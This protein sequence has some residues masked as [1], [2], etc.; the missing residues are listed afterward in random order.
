M[1]LIY[2]LGI[3]SLILKYVALLMLIPCFCALALKEYTACVP[4]VI[5]SVFTFFVSFL[6]NGKKTNEDEINNINKTEAFSVLL[7]TWGGICILGTIP[8]LYFGLNFTDSLFESVSGITA[9]GASVLK[10]YANYPK[11]MFFWRAFSQWIGGMGVIVLFTAI[12][13][14]IVSSGKQIFSVELTGS[15]ENKLT[16]R[17]KHTAIA[18]WSIYFA[19]TIIEIFLLICMKMPIFDA[20]C[21]S[22]SCISSGGFVPSSNILIEYGQLKYIW[23]IAIFMFFAG[24]NFALQYK[25]FVKRDFKTLLKN[26]EFKIYCSVILFFTI[27]ISGSLILHNTNN[28]IDTVRNSLFS[29]LSIITTSG[30]VSTDYSEWNLRAKLFLFLLMFSGA[31]VGSTTGGVKILRLIF[32]FKYMK[33]QISKI[34]HPNGVYPIKINKVIVNE[35]NVKKVIS[36]VF[37]YYVFFVITAIA[38]IYTE[39]DIV[40]GTTVAISTLGNIGIGFGN[41]IGPMGHFGD[42]QLS[43]KIISI[44]NML[45]GRLELIPFLA[46]LHTD[47][48]A[49]KKV[50]AF[51]SSLK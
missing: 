2:V 31:C 44:F 25:V 18:L 29:V 46:L 23:T 9:T 22:L 49:L 37:F 19:L 7:L 48:W 27:I 50:T 20:I 42:L 5:T 24:T 47:F 21:I 3:V 28:I 6:L 51:K 11:T 43:S 30:F 15:A 10:N 36:F 26:E 12:V 32:I 17:V 16:P 34:H 45:I 13:P 38:L 1:N 39:Q 41:I 8:F 14:H 40:T 33:R 35:E 4:F